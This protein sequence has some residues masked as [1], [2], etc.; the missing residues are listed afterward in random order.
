[1]TPKTAE[2]SHL[3]N[4]NHCTRIHKKKACTHQR[5]ASTVSRAPCS[6]TKCPESLRGCPLFV[7]ENQCLGSWHK[8]VLCS[9]F[10]YPICDCVHS[11]LYFALSDA[12]FKHHEVN[13]EYK[14]MAARELTKTM[15]TQGP[16]AHYCSRILSVGT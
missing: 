15:C 12:I 11:F 14:A 9:H 10:E 13:S 7:P 4:T 8:M 16:S 5:S 2:K 3:K 6:G 1:M